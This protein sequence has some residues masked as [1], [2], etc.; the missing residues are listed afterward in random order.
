MPRLWEVQQTFFTAH[1]TQRPLVYS[2]HMPTLEEMTAWD[3]D[4]LRAE[5]Y[6]LLPDDWH[7]DFRT[8]PQQYMLRLGGPEGVVWWQAGMSY[9]VLLFDCYGWLWTRQHKTVNPI[10][11]PRDGETLVP[12]YRRATQAVVGTT[13]GPED[14]DPAEIAMVYG[15]RGRSP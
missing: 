11:A 2:S 7:Y 12:V 15:T 4:E 1:R 13:D 8:E 5:I 14:L 9:R 10:W 3:N 6:A